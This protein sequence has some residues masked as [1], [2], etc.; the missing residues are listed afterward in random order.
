MLLIPGIVLIH[1]NREYVTKVIVRQRSD[2]HVQTKLKN[3]VY[4]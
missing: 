4:N 3:S 2:K 1:M